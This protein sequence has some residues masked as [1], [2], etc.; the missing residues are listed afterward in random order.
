MKNLEKKTKLKN[1]IVS[2]NEFIS[3][4]TSQ[5]YYSELCYRIY[6][7]NQM[8]NLKEKKEQDTR[9]KQLIA[10]YKICVENINSGKTAIEPVNIRQL[11]NKEKLQK[12]KHKE[13]VA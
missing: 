1:C 2:G 3:G 4:R 11:Y 8:Q 9:V 12:Q 5:R 7:R 6:I 13:G 10:N